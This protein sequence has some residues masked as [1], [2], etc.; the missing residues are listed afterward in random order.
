MSRSKKVSTEKRSRGKP[1]KE[2]IVPIEQLLQYYGKGYSVCV[3]AKM[4]NMSPT[5]V[6]NR[7]R[8]VM[9]KFEKHKPS[10]GMYVKERKE[11]FRMGQIAL[12]SEAL[13]EDKLRRIS[14]ERAISAAKHLYEMERLEEGKSTSNISYENIVRLEAEIYDA[15]SDF[16]KN[17]AEIIDVSE[18]ENMQNIENMEVDELNTHM[19]EL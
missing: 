11:F 3:I 1:T 14:T 10:L 9:S 2:K 5:N 6:Y 4:F 15:L 7:I 13:K 17:N 8:A 16:E 18:I 12:L 19:K